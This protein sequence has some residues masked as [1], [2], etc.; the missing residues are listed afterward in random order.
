VSGK[1]WERQRAVAERVGAEGLTGEVRRQSQA[2]GGDLV[3][4]LILRPN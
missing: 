4:H 3:S 1:R 2:E